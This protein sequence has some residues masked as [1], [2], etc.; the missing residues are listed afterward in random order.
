MSS[1]D[2][3]LALVLKSA[4]KVVEYFVQEEGLVESCYVVRR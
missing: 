2:L 1:I 3:R 4:S